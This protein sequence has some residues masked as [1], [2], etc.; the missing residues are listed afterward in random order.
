MTVFLKHHKVNRL[1]WSALCAFKAFDAPK[2]DMWAAQP[3]AIKSGLAQG[4]PPHQASQGSPDRDVPGV[5]TWDR[6]ALLRVYQFNVQPPLKITIYLHTTH[7][8]PSLSFF[9]FL[10]T[11]VWSFIISA[12]IL[13][14]DSLSSFISS[15]KCLISSSLSMPVGSQTILVQTEKETVT[16]QSHFTFN[17]WKWDFNLKWNFIP[18]HIQDS[19]KL[20]S[21]SCR[22]YFLTKKSPSYLCG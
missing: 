9:F 16:N 10:C 5:F 13:R 18:I 19:K 21:R 20:G 22:I 4:K 8:F 7:C 17:E 12:S 14:L 1:G 3:T 6:D 2:A 11:C 15:S